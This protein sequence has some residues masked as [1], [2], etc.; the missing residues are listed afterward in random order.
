M[1]QQQGE[2][3]L[4]KKQQKKLAK[5]E[6]QKEY[7]K[8]KKILKKQIK[9][10]QKQEQ[11]ANQVDDN[12]VHNQ[13]KQHKKPKE[14]YQEEMKTGIK[15][16][17][18]LQFMNQMTIQEK[19]SLY[20]QI[21]LCHSNNFKSAKPLNLIVTSL[22]EDFQQLLNKSNASNWGIQLNEKPYIDLFNKE[23]LVYLTG[24][25][26]NVMDEFN[27]EEVYIIGGL[28]DHNRLKLITYNKAI[29]QGIKTKKLPI[30]LNLKTSSILTVN[31]VF[32]ILL[33]RNN[34][35]DWSD[36]VQNTIPKRKLA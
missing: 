15:V 35:E 30:N 31:Q 16:V 18:D 32:E 25:T 14:Q 6:K 29:E 9:K 19:T 23:D 11:K 22:T 13:E 3:K 10:Q 34:G 4:S 28:V 20:K 5:K 27:Q 8:E 33:R 1:D 12:K 24:D 17:I 2:N 36:S 7:F 26:D 21:E